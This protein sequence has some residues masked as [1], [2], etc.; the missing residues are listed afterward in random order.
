MARALAVAAIALV[1]FPTAADAQ[2]CGTE[3]VLKRLDA[4]TVGPELTSPDGAPVIGGPF[5]LRIENAFPSSSG[6]LVFSAV[7]APFFDPAFGAMFW[8]GAPFISSFFTTDSEGNSARVVDLPT[9]DSSLCGVF[10][11][12]QTGVLDPGAMNGVAVSNALRLVVGVRAGRLFEPGLPEGPS[13]SDSVLGDLDGDGLRDL[14]TTP[15]LS[16]RLGLVGGGFAAT[17]FDFPTG[18]ASVEIADLTGDGDPDVLS[19]SGGFTVFVGDGNGGFF[20]NASFAGG[21]ERAVVDDFDQDGILDVVVSGPST[22]LFRGLGN[23]LFGFA[24][25]FATGESVDVA[26]GDLDEDGFQDVVAVIKSTDRVV[27]MTGDG[28]GGFQ[29]NGPFVV[30]LSPERV[31]IGDFDGDTVLDVVTANESPP[32]ITLRPGNGNGFLSPITATV[33][34]GGGEPLDLLATDLDDDGDL[35]LAVVNSFVEDVTVMLG[36]GDGTFPDVENLA[37]LH[38]PG[39]VEAVDYDLDG[40]L[41]LLVLG[42]DGHVVLEGDD[43]GRFLGVRHFDIRGGVSPDL[44]VT[45]MDH[46]GVADA[47]VRNKNALHVLLGS[48]TGPL[49]NSAYT[50]ASD[51]AALGDF[52]GDGFQDVLLED[53]LF[54]SRFS[55]LLNAGDGTLGAPIPFAADFII[56]MFAEDVNGDLATDLVLTHSGG[57]TGELSVSIA[58]G[59]GTFAAPDFYS[60]TSYFHLTELV[61]LDGDGFLD[62]AYAIDES[63]F[64]L[65]NAGDGTFGREVSYASVSDITRLVFVDLGGD[66]EPDLVYTT[67]DADAAHVRINAGDG[68]F[69]GE[70]TYAAA[71]AADS[72]ILTGDINGDLSTDLIVGIQALINQGNGTFAAGIT[73]G[74]SLG[75]ARLVDVTADGVLDFVGEEVAFISGWTAAIGVRVGRGDGT[76]EPRVTTESTPIGRIKDAPFHGP[77]SMDVIDLDGDTILDA[78]LVAKQVGDVVVYQGNGDGTFGGADPYYVSPANVSLLFESISDFETADFDGDGILDLMA[79]TT[80]HRAAVLTN[81]LGE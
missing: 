28:A 31:A 37:G 38:L 78:V 19:I 50:E 56:E 48:R 79:A 7:D 9:V 20:G 2:A 14:I 26:S 67:T 32:N 23:G 69:G 49:S 61:D 42:G 58:N 13:G 24:T 46:D 43:T 65:L 45:D 12:F 4:G 77:F 47:V 3:V 8:G 11:I 71:A 60:S 44:F 41:D 66:S 74:N 68:T 18:G 34:T 29:L 10:A 70:A 5:S 63:L 52:D 76:F 39:A 57:A 59:D 30:G 15:P 6:L 62:V 51:E 72:R 75:N 80:A 17:G 33:P 22:S 73:I 16:V 36:T 64:V 40:D 27:S 55:V 35:D 81:R 25:E 1:L 53:G 21:G 54:T